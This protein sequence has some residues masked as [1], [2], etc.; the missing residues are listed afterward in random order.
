MI[1]GSYPTGAGASAN[2]RQPAARSSAPASQLVVQSAV[3]VSWSGAQYVSD[4]RD[5]CARSA[6]FGDAGDV[7]THPVRRS[8]SNSQT[9][10][11]TRVRGL[12]S[13]DTVATLHQTMRWAIWTKAGATSDNACMDD[14]R[15]DPLD[16]APRAFVLRDVRTEETATVRSLVLAGLVEHWGTIDE[17]LNRDLDD[18][19]GA[20][21]GGRTV[22]AV[23][24]DGTVVATGTVV[25]RGD[26]T[27]EVVR[28][29]VDANRR[30]SGLGR[31]VLDELV[32]T[33]RR[34]GARRVVLET[35]AAWADVVAF[36]ERCG[37]RVTHH[38]A[39]EFGVD[40]WF[41]QVL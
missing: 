34:W 17:A 12:P 6:A 35:T 40:A 4:T 23:D 30:G 5:S 22:V 19:V 38:A 32:A 10:C 11:S 27:V 18:L 15:S 26:G 24:D 7:A 9:G 29:S 28:M 3:H 21:P 14:D 25:P 1:D 31:S 13:P 33:A 37:F 8:P 41:E 39:G 2:R 16:G 36:Y 20:Y